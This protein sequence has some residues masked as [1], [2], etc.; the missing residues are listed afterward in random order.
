[1]TAA[2]QNVAAALEYW[3]AALRSRV[4]KWRLTREIVT[5]GID[6]LGGLPFELPCGFARCSSEHCRP[7]DYVWINRRL[8][9]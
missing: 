4:T 6:H 9:A 8:K 3:I 2:I 7:D 5:S 1:M